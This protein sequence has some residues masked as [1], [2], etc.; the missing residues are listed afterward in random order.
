MEQKIKDVIT[1]KELID[2]LNWLGEIKSILRIH[3]YIIIEIQKSDG[4]IQYSTFVDNK[5][6]GHSYNSIDSA[7]AGCIAYAYEGVNH[8]A[9]YY[10]MKMIKS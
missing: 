8:R 4:N 10:F 6:C 3:R 5:N 7:L 9:D 2:T 1:D